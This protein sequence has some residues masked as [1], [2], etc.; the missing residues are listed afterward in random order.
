MALSDADLELLET[1]LDGESSPAE[2]AALRVRLGA[3]A[4]LVDALSAAES[5]RA[6][7]SAVWHGMEPDAAAGDRLLWRVRGALAERSVPTVKR[8]FGWDTWRS[9][10]FGS[11]AAACLLVGFMTGRVGRS[12][13]PTVG[14]RT[15]APTETPTVAELNRPTILPTIG[16]PPSTFVPVG[17]VASA[18]QPILVPVTNELG[19]VVS[20][21]SFATP[22]QAKAYTEESHRSTSPSMSP[23]PSP[24]RTVSAVQ[25]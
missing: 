12:A 10:G 5:A 8:R 25:F 22:E 19:Q 23:V 7:R 1:Y 14:Q 18:G 13:A 2:T 15:V 24:V 20:W 21:E 3:D 17:P 9:A 4:A 6:V 16:T 11:A